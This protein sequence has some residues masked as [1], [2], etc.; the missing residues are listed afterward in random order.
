MFITRPLCPFIVVIAQFIAPTARCDASRRL[1]CETSCLRVVILCF[2]DVLKL[3]RYYKLCPVW[4]LQL[5]GSCIVTL[6]VTV[7]VASLSF[8]GFMHGIA[9]SEYVAIE[10]AGCLADACNANRLAPGQDLPGHRAV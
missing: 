3:L 1:E 4:E 8:Q 6:C 5:S 9:T 7:T 10:Q 2:H